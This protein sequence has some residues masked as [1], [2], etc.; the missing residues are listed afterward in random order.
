MLALQARPRPA[1]V[2]DSKHGRL[3]RAETGLLPRKSHRRVACDSQGVENTSRSRAAVFSTESSKLS[4]ISLLRHL[5]SRW[6]GQRGSS[7]ERACQVRIFQSAVA[8]LQSRGSHL[9]KI[10]TSS[11]F[12]IFC[13]IF[14]F[15]IFA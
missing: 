4:S 13:K 1:R 11:L 3:G 14:Y 10:G 9:P 12:A 15:Y 8:E 6:S 5:F 2:R 7:R